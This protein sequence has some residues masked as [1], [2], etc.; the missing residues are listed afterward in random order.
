MAAPILLALY[1]LPA[2]DF[3]DITSGN[4]GDAAGPGYDLVTGIGTPIANLLVP[5]LVSYTTGT[6]L[7][8]ISSRPTS[9]PVSS[10]VPKLP[11]KL[12]M[13]AATLSP[14]TIPR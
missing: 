2:S 13:P 7:V 10:S 8:F 14:A 11:S 5:D 9:W 4:N 1:G 3:N 6:Q 12:T